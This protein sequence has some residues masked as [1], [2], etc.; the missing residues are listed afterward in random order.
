MSWCVLV[1]SGVSWCGPGV[2]LVYSVALFAS[3]CVISYLERTL[4][5]PVR[6]VPR[7]SLFNVICWGFKDVQVRFSEAAKCSDGV[8]SG[9]A[10]L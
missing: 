5:P 7:S 10:N 2:I 3:I 1:C 4:G 6:L 8:K 9:S